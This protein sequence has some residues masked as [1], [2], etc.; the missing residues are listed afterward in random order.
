MCAIGSIASLWPPKGGRLART[1]LV[2]SF[3]AGFLS[4]SLAV[5]VRLKELVFERTAH[6]LDVR[7]NRGKKVVEPLVNLVEI[8]HGFGLN[9]YKFSTSADVFP[10]RKGRLVEAASTAM[11]CYSPRDGAGFLDGENRLGRRGGGGG[12]RRGRKFISVLRSAFRDRCPPLCLGIRTKNQRLCRWF[13]GMRS[14][15]QSPAGR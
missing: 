11:P 15:S 5:A 4:R 3:I 10:S 8:T 2:R 1:F 6:A 12:F 7:V 13:F 9:A 14:V